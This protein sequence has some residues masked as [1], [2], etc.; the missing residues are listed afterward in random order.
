[1]AKIIEIPDLTENQANWL[2]ELLADASAEAL[3]NASNNHVFALGANTQEESVEFEDMAD[4]SR[5]YS[6]KLLNI[7]AQI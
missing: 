3:G 1:M 5:D 6:N 4:E 7:A 2:R